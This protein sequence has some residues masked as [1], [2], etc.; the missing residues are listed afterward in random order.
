[1]LATAHWL[2]VLTMLDI[3]EGRGLKLAS[4]WLERIEARL[5]DVDPRNLLPPATS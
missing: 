5:R 2:G 1:M 4:T 3:G